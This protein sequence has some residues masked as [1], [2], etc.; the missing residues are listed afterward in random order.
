MTVKPENRT[1]WPTNC[2]KRNSFRC[3]LWHFPGRP[4]AHPAPPSP[5]LK[6]PQ[7]SPL[8][9]HLAAGAQPSAAEVPC[10]QP[11]TAESSH[12]SPKR[13]SDGGTRF[14][15]PPRHSLGYGARLP[16]HRLPGGGA[17]AD[18]GSRPHTREPSPGPTRTARSPSGP[19]PL[20]DG[21]AA[22]PRPSA[23]RVPFRQGA[24]R[25]GAR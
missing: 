11:D 1:A 23:P 25:G 3:L 20:R 22:P 19:A 18:P 16:R 9:N 2:L 8:P 15:Q 10:R 5:P 17:E 6:L 12:F 7:R 13:S 24:G 14:H 21:R 4:P